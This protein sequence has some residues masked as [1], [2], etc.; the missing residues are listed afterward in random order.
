MKLNMVRHFHFIDDERKF[1]D[2]KD[3]AVWRGNG[4]NSKIRQHFFRKTTILFLYLTLV[5][6]VLLLISPGLKDFMS[7]YDQLSY[8]F[9]FCI[10]GVDTATSIKV[11][12]VI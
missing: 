4:M 6:K 12:N 8:K 11:G 5:R 1:K 3:M 10:E 2:K 7:I 9:I